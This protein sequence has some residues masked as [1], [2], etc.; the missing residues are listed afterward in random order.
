MTRA[1]IVAEIGINHSGNMD[2]CAA[3]IRAAKQAGAD[4]VKF[5]NYK[6]EKFIHQRAEWWTYPDGTKERQFDM[7]K[8]CELS[9]DDLQ[10]IASICEMVGID[11]FS[12]PMCIEGL[13]ELLKLEVK[14]LK[15]G[16]DCLQD[17]SL[18]NAMGATGL[19]T[20]ISTGMATAAD[21]EMAVRAFRL[22]GHHKDLTLLHCTSA[23]PAADGDMNIS[24]ML[25]LDNKYACKIGL[26][27]HSTGTT[28]AVLSVAYG[29]TFIEK[30]FTLDKT[31]PGPDHSF[32]ADPAEMA[33]VVRQIRRAEAMIGTAAL[34]MTET[35]KEN[36][37]QWFR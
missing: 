33:E 24:K 20:V 5:Q 7:F 8:R 2:L 26:S 6:T 28:A 23:Y 12:T 32:S 11:W 25:S 16:S 3:M 18:I 17:L 9:F 29:A 14:I 30:H 4:A 37:R 34:G 15:N 10:V 21:I 19:P 13:E 1:Y 22:N 35:E 36:R 27:D 31:L